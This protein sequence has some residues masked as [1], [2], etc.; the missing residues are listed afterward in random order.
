MSEWLQ[1]NIDY[2]LPEKEMLPSD[3]KKQLTSISEEMKDLAMHLPDSFRKLEN[4]QRLNI[5]LFWFS[6]LS[7]LFAFS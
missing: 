7:I 1:I 3:V 5:I 6:F 2:F 4:P